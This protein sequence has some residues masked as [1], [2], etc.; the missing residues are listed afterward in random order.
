MSDGLLTSGYQFI[1]HFI[2]QVVHVA[3]MFG[4]TC[5][6]LVCFTVFTVK[7]D[8][9]GII[10]KPMEPVTL[11]IKYLKIE[12]YMLLLDS[13]MTTETDLDSDSGWADNGACVTTAVTWRML[14]RYTRFWKGIYPFMFSCLIGV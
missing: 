9:E 5:A 12:A 13:V 3:E 11:F 1:Q 10:T 8:E 2:W 6:I 4:W 14:N 7:Y